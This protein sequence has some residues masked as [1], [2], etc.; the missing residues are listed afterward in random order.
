MQ[1]AG[2]HQM[3]HQPQLVFKS[4]ANAFAQPSQRHDFL[5]FGDG[6]GRRC[7]A[8]QKWR[9]D[10]H[11]V[12]RLIQNAPLEG[13]EIDD[14]VRKFGHIAIVNAETGDVNLVQIRTLFAAHDLVPTVHLLGQISDC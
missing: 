10:L 11:A 4:D 6:K 2:N 7:C 5:S 3:Q 12:E 1:S 9:G 13:L 8:Q 14:D